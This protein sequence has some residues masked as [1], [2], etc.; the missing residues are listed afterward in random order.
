[1]QSSARHL[2]LIIGSVLTI[3][4]ILLFFFM[5]E[6]RSMQIAGGVLFAAGAIM[7]S[8]GIKNPGQFKNRKPDIRSKYKSSQQDS[9]KTENEVH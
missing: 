9:E 2:L 5:E 1:M 3:F 8:R 4:G 7:I 6:S